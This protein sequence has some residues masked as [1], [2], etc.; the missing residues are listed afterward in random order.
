MNDRQTR[1]GSFK[2][3]EPIDHD[4]FRQTEAYRELCAEYGID[5]AAAW[6]DASLR[7]ISESCEF[8][9]EYETLRRAGATWTPEH[10]ARYMETLVL[11]HESDQGAMVLNCRWGIVLAVTDPVGDNWMI[12]A[13]PYHPGRAALMMAADQTSQA[14]MQ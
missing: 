1:A 8:L 7:S 10:V 14:S 3:P 13:Q 11:M 9:C 2:P 5:P 4:T 12:T 6:D